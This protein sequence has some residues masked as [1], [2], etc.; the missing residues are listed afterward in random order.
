MPLKSILKEYWNY[1]VG[2][3]PTSDEGNA[4]AVIQH[5]VDYGFHAELQNGKSIRGTIT[6]HHPDSIWGGVT[7]GNDSEVFKL[8]KSQQ[9]YFSTF[10]KKIEELWNSKFMDEDQARKDF[11]HYVSLTFN[12]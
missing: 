5:T 2:H 9:S 10:K 11:N 4:T 3:Y 1:P 8:P 7:N 6:V 12:K